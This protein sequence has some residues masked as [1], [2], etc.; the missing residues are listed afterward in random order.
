MLHSVACFS[1]YV[2]TL[3]D[4][5]LLENRWEFHGRGGDHNDQFN[6]H[7]LVKNAI[8][9][10]KLRIFCQGCFHLRII[11]D[12]NSFVCCNPNCVHFEQS[13]GL[14]FSENRFMQ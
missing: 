9:V 7:F 2:L 8:L 11:L 12:P 6:R 13:V 14:L 10:S 5:D 3:T 4:I 1:E